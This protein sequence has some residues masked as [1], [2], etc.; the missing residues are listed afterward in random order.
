MK[1]QIPITTRSVIFQHTN[2]PQC[3]QSLRYCLIYQVHSGHSLSKCF[4]SVLLATFHGVILEIADMMTILKFLFLSFS[5]NR[6]VEMGQ[7]LRKSENI[8]MAI[9]SVGFMFI[10]VP[11]KISSQTSKFWALQC[12][13]LLDP[14]LQYSQ[15]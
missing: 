4:E 13:F 7:N 14:E 8:K 1:I 9:P 10:F 5:A 6:L 15:W 2:S 11:C 3:T 12:I